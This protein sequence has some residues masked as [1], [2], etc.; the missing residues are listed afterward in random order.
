VFDFPAAAPDERVPQTRG[1][2]FLVVGAVGWWSAGRESLQVS[3]RGG[4]LAG[5]GPGRGDAQPQP[6]KFPGAGRAIQ[7]ER[8]H[9]GDQFAGHRD[10][11]APD[12]FLVKAVQGQVAQAGNFGGADAVLAA[13]AVAVG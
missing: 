5:P 8:L 6:F 12:L 13:R 7:G 2:G 1:L 3:D 4:E 9:P 10:Q 11:F